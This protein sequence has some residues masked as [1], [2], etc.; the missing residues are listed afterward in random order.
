[1]L[2]LTCAQCT[3]IAQ[4]VLRQ[5][6]LVDVQYQ[7]IAPHCTALRVLAPKIKSRNSYDHLS[8][9]ESRGRRAGANVV[10]MRGFLESWRSGGTMWGRCAGEVSLLFLRC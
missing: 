3:G 6:Q 4:V 2:Y 9:G 10:V 5:L 8:E 1:M 7:T